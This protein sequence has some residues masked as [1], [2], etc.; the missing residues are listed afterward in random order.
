[1]CFAEKANFAEAVAPVQTGVA[2]PGGLQMGVYMMDAAMRLDPAKG[3]LNV[4]IQNMFNTL[5]RV[6][7]LEDVVNAKELMGVEFINLL[8]YLNMAYGKETGLWFKRDAVDKGEEKQ[9]SRYV[10]LGSNMGVHQGRPMSCFLAAVGLVACLN[11]AQKALDQF[12]EIDRKATGETLT[13]DEQ[14]V[15]RRLAECKA[16]VSAYLDDASFL[17]ASAALC[18]AYDAYTQVAHKRGWLC[19][20]Q[21][22]ICLAGVHEG[23]AHPEFDCN[24]K[25]DKDG[26][27][28]AERGAANDPRIQARTSNAAQCA[29]QTNER[30]IGT[31]TRQPTTTTSPTGNT[32]STTRDEELHNSEGGDAPDNREP[33]KIL[34]LERTFVEITSKEGKTLKRSKFVELAPGVFAQNHE[35]GICN[36]GVP[37]GNDAYV[38]DALAKAMNENDKRLKLIVEYAQHNGPE[39]ASKGQQIGIQGGLAMLRYSANARNVHFLRQIS[40]RL[41]HEAAR[42]HDKSIMTAFA[43]MMGQLSRQNTGNYYWETPEA[44]IH[45]WFRQIRERLAQPTYNSGVDLKNWQRFEDAAFVGMINL[46]YM[47]ARMKT[48]TVEH[49]AFPALEYVVAQAA[50]ISTTTT[51]ALTDRPEMVTTTGW[52]AKEKNQK[53]LR[54]DPDLPRVPQICVE[55]YKMLRIGGGEGTVKWTDLENALYKQGFE[56]P[57]IDRWRQDAVWKT[58]EGDVEDYQLTEVGDGVRLR[59]GKGEALMK[60]LQHAVQMSGHGQIS[61]MVWDMVAAWGMCVMEGDR[62]YP[63][64]HQRSDAKKPGF[65]LAQTDGKLSNISLLPTQAQRQISKAQKRLAMV[66]LEDGLIDRHNQGVAGATLQLQ[67]FGENKYPGCGGWLMAIPWMESGELHLSNAAMLFNF[68]FAFGGVLPKDMIPPRECQCNCT[69]P[70]AELPLLMADDRVH[71][72]HVERIRDRID[73]VVR[74]CQ[75][76]RV[77]KIE[78]RTHNAI[79]RDLQA[80]MKTAGADNVRLEPRDYDAAVKTKDHHRP[81]VV[82]WDQVEGT[83]FYH[84]LKIAWRLGT[85]VAPPQDAGINAAREVEASCKNSYKGCEAREEARAKRFGTKATKFDPITIAIGGAHG[86]KMGELLRRMQKLSKRK[87]ASAELYGWNAMKWY[88]HWMIRI[89]VKL[90]NGIAGKLLAALNNEGSDRRAGGAKTKGKPAHPHNSEKAGIEEDDDEYAGPSSLQY[91]AFHDGGRG[92]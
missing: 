91:D 20:E 30:E 54:N 89:S 74:A 63:Q 39:T 9:L 5:C 27:N 4:D 25:D 73:H 78:T 37:I 52:N 76:P 88:K 1:M 6:Q 8:R 82:Y 21:K 58:G 31:R 86:P 83:E 14:V 33:N 36:L 41:G 2:I 13:F 38:R 56:W 87:A 32:G 68:V 35:A 80:M 81:D 79:Q 57:E 15:R 44:D 29:R 51:Q 64:P 65:W 67:D 45:P 19:V 3:Q 48:G 50:A 7:M 70:L 12:N 23:Q 16:N 34:C 10:R 47:S 72:D 85:K 28:R 62:A 90:A 17:A 53:V 84:D 49:C 11:A 43:D 24:D 60:G 92:E 69:D 61:T 59:T 42:R 77:K 75:A 66:E 55:V 22:S 26:R 46:A 40:K 18:V 71:I